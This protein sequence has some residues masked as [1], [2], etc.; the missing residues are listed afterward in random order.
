VSETSS[1]G[2]RDHPFSAKQIGHEL[3]VRYVLEGA[4]QRSGDTVRVMT[5]LL[6][7]DHS[8]TAWADRFEATFD[9]VFAAQDDIVYA[10]VEALDIEVI[11][12]EVA[13]MF[14]SNLD[15][16]TARSAIASPAPESRV[17]G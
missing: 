17:A 12:G 3:G 13:R 8:T 1:L 15:P 5:Q 2:Y 10:I 4:V 14:R 16:A 9:D 6:D 11:G 7:V